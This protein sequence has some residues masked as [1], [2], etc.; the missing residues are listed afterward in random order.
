MLTQNLAEFWENLY[1]EA[2]DIWD[3]GGPTPALKEFFKNPLCP[4][5][6]RVLVPGAGRG[7]DA[8]QWAQRGHD[9]VAVDYCAT[10]VDALDSL[11]RKHKNFLAL[12]QDLFELIPKTLGQFDIVYDYCC[13]S[14]IHPGRRDE[15]LEV[16]FKMLKDDGVVIA[17]FY[18]LGN[19]NTMQG[20]PH[21]T[22]EGELMARMDGI[23]QVEHRIMPIKSVDN[24]KGKEQI[25]LLRKVVS[26]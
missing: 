21:C 4:A 17:F 8:L 3:L 12:D 2:K 18:P 6:G 25:W 22:S 19:G 11:S 14:A 1:S 10:A 15:L 5:Q 24:R 26:E 16:W 9:T 7:Y 23:F 20:P 13:F